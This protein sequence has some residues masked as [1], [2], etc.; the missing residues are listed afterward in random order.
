MAFPELIPTS[1][2]FESG[3]YPVKTFKAQN[4]AEVRVLYGTTRTNMKLSMT[5][6]NIPDVD[7][8]QILDHYDEV[9]GT[10]QTFVVGA[11]TK[12]GWDPRDSDGTNLGNAAIGARD[13]G[14]KYRYESPPRQA[15]VRPGISTVTVNL[16]GVF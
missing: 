15:Q 6:E 13:H 10:F 12:K 2:T 5:F 8:K 1:R 14:N 16:I 4:G 9:Q 3:D 11:T 7:A